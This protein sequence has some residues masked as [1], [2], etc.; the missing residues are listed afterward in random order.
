MLTQTVQSIKPL[1][2]LLQQPAFCIGDDGAVCANALANHLAPRHKEDLLP[3]LGDSAE[4]YGKWDG[5]SGLTLPV[6]WAGQSLQ[7]CF[8]RLA[9][10]VLVLLQHVCPAGSVSSE[11]VTVSQVLRQPLADLSAQMQRLADRLDDPMATAPMQRQLYRACRLAA[12]LADLHRLQGE[13]PT[14]QVS[15]MELPGDLEEF[16]REVSGLFRELDRELLVSL[17]GKQTLL[18]ADRDLIQR[19]M[20][21]LLSNA[22]KYSPAGTPVALQV[23]LSGTHVLLQFE[24][25]CRGSSTELLQ[26][27]FC[28][29]EERGLM[30]DPRWG[31]GLGLPLTHAIARLHGGTVALEARNDAVTVTLSLHRRKLQEAASLRS[32]QLLYTGGMRQTLVELAD[33]LPNAVFRD[34]AL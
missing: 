24:N 29:L 1:L 2:Q 18:F 6:E 30:P 16:L 5:T 12:N 25:V 20:L 8:S 32:P 23:R 17:P 33:V 14:M 9:D 21:N 22:L 26:S 34:D 31:L 27:A 3:W 10:G 13:H 15:R 11:L 7:A 19:A 28:R 4:A